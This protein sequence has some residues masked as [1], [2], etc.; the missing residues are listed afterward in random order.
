MAK[1]NINRFLEKRRND[2]LTKKYLKNNVST[3]PRMN[4]NIVAIVII[5]L[6]LS[7]I[8]VYSTTYES[9][10]KDNFYSK[11]GELKNNNM[12]IVDYTSNS[13]LLGA[14]EFIRHI[15]T[16]LVGL[17]IM[18]ITVNIKQKYIKN[19]SKLFYVLVS[20]LVVLVPIIGTSGLGQTR[21]LKF[22]G[23]SV[24]PSDLYKIALILVMALYLYNANRDTLEKPKFYI[25]LIL[26]TFPF[27]GIIIYSD[28][29]TGF[30]I[31]C[32]MFV[33]MLVKSRKPIRFILL[34]VVSAAA[35][36]IGLI[37]VAPYRMARITSFFSSPDAQTLTGLHAIASG[38]LFGKGIG[39]SMMN[40]IV[41]ES[42]NDFVFTIICEEFGI[43]GGI[44]LIL[45]F[46]LLIK[47]IYAMTR[48]TK[49]PFYYL[50]LI[51]CITHISMQL[52]INISVTLKLL[53]NTGIGLPFLSKG[54]TAIIALLFEVGI[55]LN[56]SKLIHRDK[57]LKNEKR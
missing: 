14:K 30:V 36:I 22:F 11:L 3:R 35:L 26:M 8:V 6:V 57:L 1:I 21:W 20:L 7:C 45:L 53:P 32:I 16:I 43:I 23:L 4:Y 15:V 13:G 28:L 40:T 39:N 41:P 50:I 24:Q 33:Q 10:F 48:Q 9:S 31:L 19:L 46:V 44:L 55:I 47:E 5:L 51:G 34:S 42:E 52:I 56:I 27:V 37:L 17:F 38:G 18:F 2:K 12:N 54:G 49:N 29:S 25:N